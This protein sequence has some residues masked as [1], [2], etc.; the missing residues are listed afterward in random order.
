MSTLNGSSLLSGI[1]SGL[2]GTYSVLANAAGTSG[3]TL[4]SIAKAQTNTSLVN[5]LN[6]SF[7]SYIQSNFT[8]LDKDKDGILSSAELSNM[9]SNMMSTGMTQAQLTQLGTASGMSTE[10]LSQVL[11][12]FAEIDANGDGKVTTG[13]I[14]AY[15]LTSA[16]EKKADEF[17]NK[18]CSDMS[19]MYSDDSSSN[20]E[21]SSLLA[22]KYLQDK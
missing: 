12:H 20:A 9:T 14:N 8:S 13:E 22:Y 10:T 16:R 1:T 19:I 6:G 4:D 5:T 17:R 11:E 18:F 7:A 21:S 3:V 15:N 2:T